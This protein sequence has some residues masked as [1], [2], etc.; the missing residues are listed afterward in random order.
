MRERN[1][2]SDRK[3]PSSSRQREDRS[4]SRQQEQSS[5]SGTRQQGEMDRD[6]EGRFSSNR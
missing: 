1:K 3:S 2:R 6:D 4:S 5:S